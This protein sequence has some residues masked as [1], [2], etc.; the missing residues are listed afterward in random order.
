MNNIYEN[1]DAIYCISLTTTPEK[2]AKAKPLFKCL[3]FEHLVNYYITEKSKYGGIYGCFESH[4]NIMKRCYSDPNCNHVLIFEDDVIKGSFYNEKYIQNTINFVNNN[5]DWDVLKL[6]AP[7]LFPPIAC[8]RKIGICKGYS[9]GTHAYLVSRKGMK[10]HIDYF[11]TIDPTEVLKNSKTVYGHNKYN[12]DMAFQNS[13][14]SYYIQL[15]QFWQKQGKP[16]VEHKF[17][18]INLNKF[19]NTQLANSMLFQLLTFSPMFLTIIVSSSIAITLIILYN[20]LMLVLL[21][22]K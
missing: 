8:N 2:L 6:G 21:I 1:F 22:T 11:N 4:V 10:K 14:N 12:F 15:P 20:I 7:T 16:N 3:G 5:K 19:Q 13:L 17:L 9:L 18:G